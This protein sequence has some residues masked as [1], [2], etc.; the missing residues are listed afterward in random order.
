LYQHLNKRADATLDLLD[1]L[2]SQTN[3]RSVVELSLNP[4]FRRAYHSL[5]RAIGEMGL[6][7]QALARLAAPHL[8]RGEA[9]PFYRLCV[10]VT[11]QPRPFADCLAD[12]G[13]VYSG[14]GKAVHLGH[15]YSTVVSL[16]EVGQDEQSWV[17][18]LAVS[19]VP[20]AADKELLG[21]RQ[22]ADLLSDEALPF[23]K[24]LTVLVGDTFYSKP[25]FLSSLL[26]DENLVIL[27]R[28]RADRVFYRQSEQRREG[29]G[30][31][32]WYGERFVLADP[33]TW[34]AADEQW[35]TQYR[36][37]RGHLRFVQAS[38]WSNLLMRGKRKP[39]PMAM[40]RYPFTLIRVVVTK[41]DGQPAFRRPLWL[42][43]IGQRRA[44]ISLAHAYQSFQ[45]RFRQEHAFRF[46]K[47]RL[48]LTAF[49]T[50][51]AEMEE[52]WWRLVHLA[53][54]QLWI[55][56]PLTDGLPRPWERYRPS[57]K[58]RARSPTLVQ[59]DLGRILRQLGT[60][61]QA[62]KPRGNSP[63]RPVGF[64]PQRRIR[65]PPVRKRPKPG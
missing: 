3:A 25:A 28:V 62:V 4:C 51:Q 53:Y 35:T 49:Q 24:A 37:Q 36:S 32:K 61:A 50:P 16:P 33:E 57:F 19:R 18:P 42:L 38:G 1:A 26:P 10:D 17:L 40:Q 60:P 34:S 22:V 21:A 47:Q 63:G 29:R 2:S 5:Y 20:T 43:L 41:Q 59:R 39:W 15:Q 54:L 30:R 11:P 6:S 27:V 44:E 13:F 9:W 48:L 14:S 8:P 46:L 7:N 58:A 55:A 31:Q 52:A 23:A 45:Q 12:R 64:H 56:R 65:H